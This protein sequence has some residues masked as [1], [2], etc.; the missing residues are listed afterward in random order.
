[1]R[2][3]F[4][5]PFLIRERNRLSEHL[6]GCAEVAEARKWYALATDIRKVVGG[7]RQREERV[8]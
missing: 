1:M 5:W 3:R 2:L 7:A 4:R 8:L 6:E